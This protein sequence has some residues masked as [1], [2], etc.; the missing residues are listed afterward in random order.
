MTLRLRSALSMIAMLALAAC[1]EGDAAKG[2]GGP[3]GPT[4]SVVVTTVQPMSFADRIEAVGTAYARESTTIASTVTER[5]VRLNFRDGE[6]VRRG[7]VIAELARSEEAAGLNEAQA[8]L[9]EAQQQ[10]TRL[11]QLQ[12]R[13]FATNAR[14]D[15][16]VAMVNAARAQ[17]GAVQAQ[18]GDRVIRAPFSGVVGLR[19]ISPGAT[20]TAGTEIATISDLSQIKLD[21]SL[22]ETFLAAMRVGQAI[23]AR[24]AAYPDTLFRGQ[25]ESIEPTVDP[26]T[27]SVTVRAVLPNPDA[28]LKPGMLMTV[29]VIANPRT[30]PAVPELALVAERDRSFVFKVD[31]ENT[32]LKTPVEVGVRQEGMVEVKRGLRPGD[33]V[34]AEG[35]IKVRDGGKVRTAPAPAA[36]GRAAE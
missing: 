33:R 14:V 20:V 21:F 24:A 8:R 1:G 5:I 28:R 32:A 9:T 6:Y 19:R 12:E 17:A 34:V 11:R 7:D 15:E 27:R 26:V 22:P 2:P 31:P 25:V 16:Q 29:N 13:G 30:A 36:S 18:I 10:L 3:G 4:P 35:T 23:E